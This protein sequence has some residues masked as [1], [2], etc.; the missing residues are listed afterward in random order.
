M[1][2]LAQQPVVAVPLQLLGASGK[3]QPRGQAEVRQAAQ[4]FGVQQA[5]MKQTCELPHVVA[6]HM[7]VPLPVATQWPF[8]HWV[9]PVQAVPSVS[10]DTHVP[11]LHHFPM[12]QSVSMVQG[13][14][15]Y[16]FGSQ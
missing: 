6:Q 1:L 7:R 2:E 15:W 5:P 11:A 4:T 10:F 12:S 8:E 9:S 13:A 3:P 16:V 14:H